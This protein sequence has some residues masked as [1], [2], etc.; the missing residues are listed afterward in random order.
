MRVILNNKKLQKREGRSF[1]RGKSTK[2]ERFVFQEKV[3]PSVKHGM[4]DEEAETKFFDRS[5]VDEILS[6]DPKDKEDPIGSIRDD[7]I[8]K[9]RMGMPT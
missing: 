7:E 6:N 8:W 3:I 1:C 9:N 5:A 2:P 4:G